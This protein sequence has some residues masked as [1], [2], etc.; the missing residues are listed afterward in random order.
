MIEVVLYIVWKETVF[1]V[2]LIKCPN[3]MDSDREQCV[4]QQFIKH[5]FK[6]IITGRSA[7]D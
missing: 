1:H 3:A 4:F 5:F 7:G 2:K 6:Y